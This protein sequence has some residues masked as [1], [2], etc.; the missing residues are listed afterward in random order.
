MKKKTVPAILIHLD[1]KTDGFQNMIYPITIT[2]SD[3]K[4][5]IIPPGETLDLKVVV[6]YN[7]RENVNAT[8]KSFSYKLGLITKSR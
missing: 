3:V 4:G 1:Y 6:Y 7:K 5:K 2:L 8:P